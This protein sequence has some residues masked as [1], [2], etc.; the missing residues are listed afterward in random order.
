[1]AGEVK[2]ATRH[3][4][5]PRDP[6]KVSSVANAQGVFR[7]GPLDLLPPTIPI[8]VLYL[9]P[10]SAAISAARLRDS[11]ELLL[12]HY[13]QLSGRLTDKYELGT[14]H[15]DRLGT[16]V[17]FIEATSD[18]RLDAIRCHEDPMHLPGNGLDLLPQMDWSMEAATTAPL[19]AFQL[20]TFACGSVVLG[21]SIRHTLTDAGGFA[22]L[23]KDLSEIYDT[24]RLEKPPQIRPYLSELAATATETEKEA[25]RSYTPANLAL[26]SIASGHPASSDISSEMPP[27]SFQPE[28]IVGR[29]LTF[30]PDQ[31]TQIKRL[32][33]PT[34][35]KGHI[36][37]YSALT[38]YL[39]QQIHK[40]R[41]TAR[42]LN[43]ALPAL[44]P[45]HFL[46]SINLRPQLQ[47]GPVYFPNAVST[48]TIT[49]LDYAELSNMPLAALATMIHSSARDPAFYQPEIDHTLHW[50]ASQ[51]D[52]SK[53]ERKGFVY[54]PGQMM[55]SAWNKFDAFGETKFGGV[56][57]EMVW[58][59]FNHAW[60]A[61][62]GLLYVLRPPGGVGLW[63]NLTLTEATWGVLEK[64]DGFCRLVGMQ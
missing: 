27:A 41:L 39:F 43:P 63:G 56:A 35:G 6:S 11:I 57:P 31:I 9:Y 44:T 49:S 53:I 34:N 48:P 40:A 22:Q 26:A 3:V 62:D 64:D 1:M 58:P 7:L 10:Q 54:G 28:R 52:K 18:L 59:P 45:P 61:A 32:A 37:T 50:I 29:V 60:M 20:T 12:D 5:N 14:Y 19:L 2:V 8:S 42:Q 4:I 46:H 24:G 38:A 51:V 30:S 33:S 16:G 36:S 15:I 21:V 47:V 55:V 23:V 17:D 25:Y 13:P